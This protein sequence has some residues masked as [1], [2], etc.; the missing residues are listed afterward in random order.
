[1]IGFGG[2]GG[3]GGRGGGGG[4][5]FGDIGGMGLTG[6]I[7]GGPGRILAVA[8]GIGAVRH[9]ILTTGKTITSPRRPL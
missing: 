5:G 2:F 1:M 7:P 9:S 4:G 6:G 8:A 3:A